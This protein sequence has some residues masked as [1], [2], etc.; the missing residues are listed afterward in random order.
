MKGRGPAQEPGQ[1]RRLHRAPRP[2]RDVPAGQGGD[3]AHHVR[4]GPVPD[5]PLART[6]PC[7]G[8]TGA[9]HGAAGAEGSTMRRRL[10]EPAGRTRESTSGGLPS[11]TR[12]SLPL[13]AGIPID[14]HPFEEHRRAWRCRLS[15][16][17]RCT[18]TIRRATFWS[19]RPRGHWATSRRQLSRSETVKSGR[20]TIPLSRVRRRLS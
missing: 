13:P 7:G 8:L 12:W 9:R 6:A 17:S 14:E 19:L 18:S 15:G 1:D 10:K 4:R 16:E 3:A 2:L 5:Q 11:F 20:H